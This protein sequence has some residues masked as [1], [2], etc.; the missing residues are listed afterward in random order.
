[1]KRLRRCIYYVNIVLVIVKFEGRLCL[2]GGNLS[3][4]DNYAPENNKN[5]NNE[6]NK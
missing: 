3:P 6:N 1:M 4:R 5:S 2:G